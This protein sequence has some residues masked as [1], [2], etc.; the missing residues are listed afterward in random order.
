MRP[1]R[2]PTPA[3][4]PVMRPVPN[5]SE[6]T[7]A[8]CVAALV[9]S[10]RESMPLCAAPLQEVAAPHLLH[11]ESHGHR[12]MPVSDEDLP[13]TERLTYIQRFHIAGGLQVSCVAPAIFSRILTWCGCTPDEFLSDWCATT[14]GA[15]AQASQ[16]KSSST[17]LWSQSRTFMMKT[18]N[19]EEFSSLQAMLP[20]YYTYLMG[21]PNS[22]LP[23]HLGAFYLKRSKGDQKWFTVTPNIIC[24][25]QNFLRVYDLK[26]STFHRA[27]SDKDAASVPPLLKDNDMLDRRD[28]VC[29][30]TVSRK[31][32]MLQLEQDVE[33]LTAANRMDYSLLVGV[34]DKEATPMHEP[35]HGF[36]IL[37]DSAGSPV[38]YAG[39]IDILQ[40]YNLKKQFA[41][42]LKTTVAGAPEQQLSTVPADAYG[43]RFLGFMSSSV[44]EK[45]RDAYFS[46][47]LDPEQAAASQRSAVH[48]DDSIGVGDVVGRTY[49]EVLTL[50]VM[51][52]NVKSLVVVSEVRLPTTATAEARWGS[53]KPSTPVYRPPGDRHS[54]QAPM[55]PPPAA[56]PEQSMLLYSCRTGS[57][58]PVN[59]VGPVERGDILIPSGRSD[60]TA[61]AV[62]RSCPAPGYIM[63]IVESV[64]IR[65]H[66]TCPSST[67][68]TVVRATVSEHCM[69]DEDIPW[70]KLVVAE[71]QSQWGSQALWEHADPDEAV[72]LTRSCLLNPCGLSIVKMH[73]M[74]VTIDWLSGTITR[75]G[76]SSPVRSADGVVMRSMS[77]YIARRRHAATA[78][79]DSFKAPAPLVEANLLLS[80]SFPN[81]TEDLPVAGM[82]PR[83]KDVVKRA[84]ASLGGWL[85]SWLFRKNT[86]SFSKFAE[87]ALEHYR[88]NQRSAA[89][90]L[91]KGQGVL[92]RIMSYLTAPD[93]GFAGQACRQWHAHYMS[94]DLWV[95]TL[96]QY[97]VEC[98]GDEE[99]PSPA[100]LARL[101][102]HQRRSHLHKMERW[103]EDFGLYYPA[104]HTSRQRLL[105]YSSH[106]DLYDLAFQRSKP[107]HRTLIDIV[108]FK[109]KQER[110]AAVTEVWEV[111][112]S[113]PALWP[114]LRRQWLRSLFTLRFECVDRT[115]MPKA[116][117]HLR[118]DVMAWIG[119]IPYELRWEDGGMLVTLD[120]RSDMENVLERYRREPDVGFAVSFYSTMQ[121]RRSVISWEAA[122]R[123]MWEAYPGMPGG[124]RLR[125]AATSP[126][127]LSASVF[128]DFSRVTAEAASLRATLIDVFEQHLFPAN[129]GVS[130][131]SAQSASP[132]RSVEIYEIGGSEDV[133]IPGQVFPV[134]FATSHALVGM[135][136]VN[137]ELP[138]LSEE[139]ASEHPLGHLLI[140]GQG[141]LEVYVLCSMSH[142]R[143]DH[144]ALDRLLTA[145]DIIVD[146]GASTLLSYTVAV[147]GQ[148]MAD[149][150]TYDLPPLWICSELHSKRDDIVEVLAG[151]ATTLDV[152]D[153]RAQEQLQDCLQT[154]IAV[155]TLGAGLVNEKMS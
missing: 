125:P 105:Q 45:E 13:T 52:P 148:H 139:A 114:H 93:L 121:W 4:A 53:Q 38:V 26:G 107:P 2:M 128:D 25:P 97:G 99:V 47:F 140:A 17:F 61:V 11:E 41:H 151:Q 67:K 85:R 27:A 64:P 10:V 7:V 147:E 71:L 76:R 32:C 98:R 143:C 149:G 70:E 1:D 49:S 101:Y 23:R 55:T 138:R 50:D 116:M 122:K 110:P 40:D 142:V 132:E 63:G 155:V 111:D 146:G 127:P 57:D 72:A 54:A 79:I 82:T 24:S 96:S 60:G 3:S 88:L 83:S 66:Q 103:D 130:I 141:G 118:R 154:D 33:W 56:A 28:K 8:D 120:S 153:T 123:R 19:L 21:N 14:S 119:S 34:C 62:P 129:R 69:A 152:L 42:T 9:H 48:R 94:P 78:F 74:W 86:A 37:R 92:L 100:C 117:R 6:I 15:E 44:F 81:S 112:K 90:A 16:G 12:H 145:I 68:F 73:D 95:D 30:T 35:S 58:V 137:A 136:E 22:L 135:L 31:L 133:T 144:A 65:M 124:S 91:V 102:Q 106:L 134:M 18:I 108:L 75:G 150:T 43:K 5:Q 89:A 109:R 39:I 80:F 46:F 126:P 51:S 20:S 113:I 29:V 84:E 36:S 59:V 131:H 115:D 77:M 104:Y 87:L